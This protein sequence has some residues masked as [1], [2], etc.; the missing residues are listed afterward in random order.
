MAV[1]LHPARPPGTDF[2]TCQVTGFQVHRPVEKIVLFNAVF[3]V[4]AIALGGILALFMALTRWQEM[5]IL[6]AELFYRFT[7]AHGMTML[8]F[9]IVFFEVAALQFGSTVLINARMAGTRFAWFYS[10]MMAVGAITAEVAA[11]SG[12][13]TIMFTAYPPMTAHWSFFLGIILFAV[14]ALLGAC[15]FIYNIWRAKQEG[16]LGP[17]MPLVVYALLSAAIMAI[18]TLLHGAASYVPMF[19]ESV[20]LIGS[21]DP[22]AYRT[23]FWAFGHG[24]QQVNLAAMV[25]CWYALASITTGARPVHEGLSRFAFVLYLIGINMGSMH[26]LLVDPGPSEHNRIINTSYLMYAATLGSLIHAFSIPAAVETALRAKGH[27][28]G[29][30]GWLKAAPWGQPGF[31]ALVIS[32]TGFGFVAGVTG[33]MMGTMQLNM[34]IHNTLFVPGHFHSTVVLGTTLAFMG[35][36]Y[37]VVPLV[38]R[39]DLAFPKLARIQPY[40]YGSGLLI[41]IAGMMLA[42]KLGAPRRS[43]DMSYAASAIGVDLF[44]TPQMNF[45]TM[46]I[47]IGAIIAVTGG[48]LFVLIMVATVFFG[49][50]SEKP[51]VG[52]LGILPGKD[53]PITEVRAAEGGKKHFH[54]R[55]TMALVFIFLTW[56]VLMY[57]TG[58]FNLSRVGWSIG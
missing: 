50:R 46:V 52:L 27:N 6:S 4:L 20:G 1:P 58:F 49:K 16:V 15:H 29:L 19:L 2:R 8:V 51:A 47:G 38:A 30:F 24:A 39:R 55:G 48:A 18:W 40:L 56:F 37:Y 53:G 5:Q 33:V 54:T 9:W 44:N 7:T 12:K 42:G 13:A 41:L 22:A 26:H 45:A 11:L 32:F 36:A 34:L 35:L 21:V 14:G 17:T 25:A 28:K 10:V 57:F 23:L 3:A 31:S 43:W